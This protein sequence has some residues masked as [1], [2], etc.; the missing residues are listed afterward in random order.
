[1]P[2]KE[3]IFEVVHCRGSPYPTSDEAK[4][5][6]ACVAIHRLKDDLELHIKDANYKDIVF[7]KNIYNH[8][9][10]EH[11]SLYTKYNKL[12]W[13]YRLLKNSYNSMAQKD[14]YAAERVKTCAAINECHSVVN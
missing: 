7:Y 5:D 1:M 8:L 13:E 14:E 9:T 2:P 11:T 3:Y 10:V 12:K 4:H 6:A